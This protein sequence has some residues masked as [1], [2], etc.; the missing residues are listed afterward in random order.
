MALQIRS[1]GCLI[2]IVLSVALTLALN[3]A[4]RGCA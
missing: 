3:L 1:S 4:V 2:S